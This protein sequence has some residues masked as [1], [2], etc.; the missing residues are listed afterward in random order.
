MCTATYDFLPDNHEESH[1]DELEMLEGD[2][3]AIL[4]YDD[5]A[6][7]TGR[8]ERTQAVGSF[9]MNY[10]AVDGAVIRVDVTIHAY[11]PHEHDESHDDELAM[12]VGDRIEVQN[13]VDE[14]WSTGKNTRTG[15][16]GD[17]PRNHCEL[18][19]T[20]HQVLREITASHDYAPA[21]HDDAESGEL[22]FQAG[23]RIQV[24]S[25]IDEN[26][27]RGRCVRTQEIG[28][29]PKNHTDAGQ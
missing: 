16:V 3:V 26:W 15:Q 9:P 13:D 28:D 11:A 14:N 20:E 23:D 25:D 5:D 24:Y 27:A 18:E 1:N 8:N 10:V 17:Y 19:G 29:F 22:E 12:E 21:N 6:W 4:S 7:S 2:R